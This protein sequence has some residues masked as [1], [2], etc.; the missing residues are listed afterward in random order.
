MDAKIG[1]I[2]VKPAKWNKDGDLVQDEYAVLTLNIPMDSQTQKKEVVALTELL[3]KEHVVV[4]VGLHR[5]EN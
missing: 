1:Q 2:V 3:D 4:D 5:L